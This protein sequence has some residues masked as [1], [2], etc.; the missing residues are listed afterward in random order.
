MH[1]FFAP[2][3][4]PRLAFSPYT[5]PSGRAFSIL[6][7]CLT[8]AGF[9]RKEPPRM[10]KEGREGSEGRTVRDED[11]CVVIFFLN[12]KN[13]MHRISPLLTDIP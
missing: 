5:S 10:D 1:F 12:L 2:Y 13:I 6:P 11:F 7:D 3:I 8:Q 9:G 4:G